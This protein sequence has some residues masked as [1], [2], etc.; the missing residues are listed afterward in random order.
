MVN[1]QIEI[2]FHIFKMG[3][4]GALSRLDEHFDRNNYAAG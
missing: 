1:G 4:L 3:G 2:I